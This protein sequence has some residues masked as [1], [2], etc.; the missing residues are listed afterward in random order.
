MPRPKTYVTDFRHLP[1]VSGDEV[2]SGRSLASFLASIVAL[3][4]LHGAEFAVRSPIRCRCRP[5]RRACPGCI[6]VARRPGASELEWQCS[7]CEFNGIIT[8][9]LGSAWDLADE[10]PIQDVEAVA[11]RRAPAPAAI[12]GRWR[13][14][15]MEVWGK[16]VLDLV[17]PAYID[18]GDRRGSFR[19][20]AVE[21]GLDCRYCNQE[22]RPIVDF[23][24]TGAD[25][26]RD[27]CGRGWARIG[28]GGKLE[29]RFFIH[30]GDDSSFIATRLSES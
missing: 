16:D 8:N 9:W 15:E 1:S 10:R 13:I 18:F 17:E 28:A 22:G 25:D 14:V 5:S 27:T 6:L 26:G 30:D 12:A 21:G 24:W 19:F 3:A 29:G 7:D 2:E 20:V 11:P 23:S 4:S